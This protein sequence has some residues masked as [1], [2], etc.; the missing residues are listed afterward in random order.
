MTGPE[1]QEL[2]ERMLAEAGTTFEGEDGQIWVGE[3]Q[4]AHI[5][6]AQLHA[7]LA[8]AEALRSLTVRIDAP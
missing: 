6:I 2:A 7:T 8:V 5:A 1:H 3:Y 4:A